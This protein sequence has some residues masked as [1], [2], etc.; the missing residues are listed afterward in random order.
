VVPVTTL[1]T[2]T[3]K[4]THLSSAAAEK[5]MNVMRAATCKLHITTWNIAAINNNPSEYLITYEGNPAYDELM[6]KV[7][8]FLEI[9]GDQDVPVSQVFTD[10]MFTELLDAKLVEVG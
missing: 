5:G 9:P 10:A 4:Q 8:K 6:V 3:A 1:E 2:R 7:D